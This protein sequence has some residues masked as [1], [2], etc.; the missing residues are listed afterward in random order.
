VAGDWDP[1]APSAYVG[2]A[3]ALRA[4]VDPSTIE[5]ARS[6]VDENAFGQALLLRAEGRLADALDAFD[7]IDARFEWATTA[8]L[9]GDEVLRQLTCA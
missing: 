3:A 6:L 4:E 1:S 8:V 9:L 2:F 7:R 5:R